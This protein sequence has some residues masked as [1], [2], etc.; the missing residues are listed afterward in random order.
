MLSGV[1]P[2]S[3]DCGIYVLGTGKKVYRANLLRRK[4]F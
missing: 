3:Q 4:L 1:T 2:A